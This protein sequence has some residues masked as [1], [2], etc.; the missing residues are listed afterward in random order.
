MDNTNKSLRAYPDLEAAAD[1]YAFGSGHVNPVSALD[2]GLVYDTDPLSYIDF[3]C[4]L[5]NATTINAVFSQYQGNSLCVRIHESFA[6]QVVDTC[7]YSEQAIACLAPRHCLT[8]LVRCAA[9]ALYAD[10]AKPFVSCPAQ[11][12]QAFNLNY[13]SISVTNLARRQVVKR[14]VTNVGPLANVQYT[15]QVASPRGVHVSVHPKELRFQEIG[16]RL[17][18]LVEIIVTAQGSDIRRGFSHLE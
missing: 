6:L 3:L 4:S 8:P 12:L 1:E 17:E 2:P 13:P 5:E 16:E 10:A 7:H 15:A 18:F 11:P 9:Q 14:V